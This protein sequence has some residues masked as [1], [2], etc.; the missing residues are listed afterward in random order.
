MA[1]IEKTI[2]VD[3]PVTTA[4]NQWTQFEE[5]PSFLESI[6]SVA[7]LDDTTLEWHA[8]IAGNDETW[9]A[10]ITDQVPDERVRWES[11]SGAPNSGE[12]MPSAPLWVALSGSKVSTSIRHSW[13]MS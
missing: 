3:V 13:A 5:F 4:Y 1:R 2:E 8:N 6:E 7:Q 9:T 12:V 10:K 11:T